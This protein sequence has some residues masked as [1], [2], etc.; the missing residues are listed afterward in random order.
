MLTFF[1]IS[2]SILTA[3]P[4]FDQR[5]VTA[6]LLKNCS[7]DPHSAW[8]LL[9]M[10]KFNSQC[11]KSIDKSKTYFRDVFSA[12]DLHKK[13]QNLKALKLLQ[14]YEKSKLS[15]SFARYWL[16]LFYWM[17]G[18]K[19]GAFGQFDRILDDY[20][21]NFIG[22][23]PWDL[24]S[25][26][27]A[28]IKKRDWDTA[29]KIFETLDKKFPSFYPGLLGGALYDH[30]NE[31]HQRSARLINKAIKISPWNPEVLVAYGNI[32]FDNPYLGEKGK[33]VELADTAL[34]INPN[35]WEAEIL[36]A[37]V[38]LYDHDLVKT[39]A[40]IK[41]STK[42]YPDSHLSLA[43]N[44]AVALL[45]ANK[46]EYNRIEA[47]VSKKY[48]LFG[49]F[50]FMVGKVLNR[51]HRYKMAADVFK[52]GLKVEPD[53][54]PMLAW[55]GLCLLRSG[56]EKGGIYYIREAARI[57]ED[58]VMASNILTLYETRILPEYVSERKGNFLYRAP[59]SEWKIISELVP[60]VLDAAWD[61][62]KKHYGYEPPAPIRIEFFKDPGDFMVLVAGQPVESGILGVCFGK[63]ISFLSPSSAK[64]NWAMVISHELAH[65]F[66]V[67][68][69]GGKVPRWFT[70]GLAELE[71][72][73]YS[74]NWKREMSRN[75][76]AALKLDLLKG[77]VDVDT[78]FSHAR[79]SLEM[80]TAYI[81]ST[82][83]L[84][85][86]LLTTGWKGIRQALKEYAA[87]AT[88]AQMITR[89]TGKTPR[90]F[91]R[92]FK[93]YL[94]S[95]LKLYANQFDPSFA[96]HIPLKTIEKQLINKKDAESRG[97]LAFYYFINRMKDKSQA[98]SRNLPD[99]SP[100]KMMIKA[101]DEMWTRKVDE[102]MKTLQNLIKLG[103][104]G[105]AVR[106][107][108][109]NL[110]ASNS[111]SN[112]YVENLKAAHFF[113]P[114]NLSTLKKLAAWYN[115]KSDYTNAIKYLK[116]YARHSEGDASASLKIVELAS[117]INDNVAVAEFGLQ[118]IEIAPFDAGEAL[119]KT[120]EALF[121]QGEY[122]LALPA[123]RI[124]FHKNPSDRYGKTRFMLAKSLASN[125]Q[126]KEAISILQGLIKVF[127]GMSEAELLLKKLQRR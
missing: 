120:A 4:S 12:V 8:Q 93:E 77:V 52:Q 51:H 37:R 55:L 83:I 71:T 96:S 58:Y 88:T 122:A 76:Y 91:D 105:Y 106:E 67:E 101:V 75:M 115:G 79:S 59:K 89:V 87:G 49:G 110:Y 124:Y 28:A 5:N 117:K 63:V 30:A 113:D 16:G 119:F 94:K 68:M 109:T 85:Y 62:Y 102:A 35:V 123:L 26:G 116:I 111:D 74:N 42:I 97:I 43:L 22:K 56:D 92:L 39:K 44:A 17:E 125:G 31:F 61:R 103:H 40:H 24:F 100:W 114:E 10:G 38:A 2:I 99:S 64:A 70:E 126:S 34:K 98:I 23:D 54:A 9:H 32:L 53:N 81:H 1:I 82:W 121:K 60:P 29:E 33:A 127:P 14:K 48:P 65:T 104:D 112:A 19:N 78:S 41:N 7:K 108:L 47:E 20:S 21:R 66:H 80:V 36:K 13:G 27:M 25:A 86:M 72:A 69:T 11:L 90:E 118:L 95:A 84:R 6:T 15:I 73:W 18:N 3:D 57:E 107:V 50:Y 46:K 45:E